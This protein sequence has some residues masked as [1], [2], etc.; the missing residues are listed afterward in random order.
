MQRTA[1][2]VTAF[3]ALMLVTAGANAGD[4]RFASCALWT[5]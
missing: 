4:A 3:I 2:N 1:T 5:G